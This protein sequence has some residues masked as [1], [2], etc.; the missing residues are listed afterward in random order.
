MTTGSLSFANETLLVTGI[1]E[2]IQIYSIKI[3]SCGFP[4]K[5]E[6]GKING[7]VYLEN[8]TLRVT[9]DG[10]F[11]QQGSASLWCQ[12]DGQ[13][14]SALPLCVEESKQINVVVVL[15]IALAGFTVTVLMIWA[16]CPIKE[17]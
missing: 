1:L 3:V 15:L 14:S 8:S 9:C 4:G 2:T 13:W 10:G 11:Y 6:N 16:L 17:K 7:S 12:G 5:V